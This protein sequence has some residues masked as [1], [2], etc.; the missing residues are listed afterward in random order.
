MRRNGGQHITSRNAAINGIIKAALTTAEVPSRLEPR[1]LARDDGKRPDGVTSV[2][3][4]EGRCLMWDV[5]CPNTLAS[6][7]V[8][9]AVTGPGAVATGAEARKRQK[10]HAIDHAVYKC[11]P[12]AIETLGAYG[13]DSWDFIQLGRRLRTVTQDT[14]SASYLLQRL[15]V[16][17]QRGN[18]AC[19][20]GTTA[21][22]EGQMDNFAV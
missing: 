17:V 3:W 9:K 16:A 14:R 11:Q 1:G 15:S 4:Q 20:L 22:N 21:D 7:Y 19:I 8:A 5:A 13:E 18:A 2:P 12:V 6:S 10:Y